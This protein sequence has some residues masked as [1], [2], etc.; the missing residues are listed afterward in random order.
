M[1]IPSLIGYMIGMATAMW[2][3]IFVGPPTKLQTFALSTV[4]S[5]AIGVFEWLG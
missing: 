3:S 5:V 4:F 1:I 2:L